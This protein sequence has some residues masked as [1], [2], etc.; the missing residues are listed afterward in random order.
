LWRFLQ[1]VLRIDG[2]GTKEVA[3]VTDDG[4]MP[5]ELTSRFVS[6]VVGARVGDAMGAPTEG[7]EPA[8][9]D[10][11]F[12]WVSD[13]AGDGTD[14]SLMATMLAH[15]LIRTAGR[16]GADDWA[17]QWMAEAEAIK[18]KRNKFF[19][20]VLH[21]IQKLKYGWLPSQVAAGNMP[22]SSSAMAI[23]PVGLVNC[24]HP[25]EAA[26][27][28]YA[29]AALIHV[30]EVDFCQ[31]AAAAIA[32]A[33]AAG[34]RPGVEAGE[35]FA[36]ALASLRPVSG[37][38]MRALIG[39]A[40]ELAGSSGGYNDFRQAYHSG[41]RQSIMCDSR[42]TVP[43]AF[44]LALL[45]GGDLVRAVEYAANFGRDADTIASMVGALCGALQGTLPLPADWVARLGD[46]ATGSAM[47][48][49]TN[50]AGAARVK[51][52]CYLKE[53]GT[54]PGLDTSTGSEG[55]AMDD[56]D[57]DYSNRDYSDRDYSDRDCANRKEQRDA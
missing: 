50:L 33:V 27:Q 45:A 17:A 52:A 20:S 28:A 9:I 26:A 11:R 54:V 39:E 14:D 21:T 37:N 32:A 30:G 57:R 51:A 36:A 42:E 16:A 48:L 13:F 55:K 46:E 40:L 4:E 43:A 41:W 31:D 15:A 12:G 23:W 56:S 47:D 5:D 49:A 53:L 18:A 6:V 8:E 7:L 1:N 24:G 34:L 38:R 29:L 10:E 35:A 44:G 2:A 25:A 19:L 3:T 22:S